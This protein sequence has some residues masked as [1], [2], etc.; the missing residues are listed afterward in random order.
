V[1][2]PGNQTRTFCFYSDFLIGTL[3]VLLDGKDLIYNIGNSENEISMIDLANKIAAL[4]NKPHL[5]ELVETPEVYK[6]EPK[7]RCPSI[8]KAKKELNY[9]PSISLDEMLGKI[10]SWAKASY[11]VL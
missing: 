4:E 10:H 2:S 7:R 11:S 3:K 1:F 8:E 6:H 9:N 5:V